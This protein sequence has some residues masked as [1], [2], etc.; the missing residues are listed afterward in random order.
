MS[1]PS[2]DP[3][4]DVAG[5]ELLLVNL[6]Y[7]KAMP[8]PEED[9]PP[10]W[11]AIADQIRAVAAQHGFAPG[12]DPLPRGS[13]G[14]FDA[15]LTSGAAEIFP[16]LSLYEA[17][18][19][20]PWEYVALGCVPDVVWWRWKTANTKEP[21]VIATERI[22]MTEPF[23]HGLA[24]HWI[25]AHIL[26][27][28][29]CM[30][31]TEDELVGLIERPSLAASPEVPRAILETH[32]RLLD[33]RRARGASSEARSISR[34]DVFRDAMKRLGR[35]NV[36]RPLFAL[37]TGQVSEIAEACLSESWAAFEEAAP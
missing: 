19:D 9:V 25:R 15:D 16:D 12:G 20:S 34:E 30:K 14:G 4:M 22:L 2:A 26:G 8:Q 5:A 27:P 21:G 3:M 1:W 32:L 36:L 23:R 29:L 37:P 7:A 13:G 10:A 31:A 18:L 35:I 17:Y 28:E 6:R 11:V 33:G 24:R